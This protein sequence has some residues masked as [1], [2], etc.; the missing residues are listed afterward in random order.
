MNKKMDR[1]NILR[2][3]FINREDLRENTHVWYL[4]GDNINR[5]GMG[6][7][8]GAMRGEPNAIGIATKVAPFDD[9]A[10]FFND[11]PNSDYYFNTIL[12]DFKKVFRILIHEI[13]PL[14]VIPYDG[15]GTG[16]SDLPTHAPKLNKWLNN[17]AH[18]AVLIKNA[19]EVKRTMVLTAT[20]GISGREEDFETAYELF[21]EVQNDQFFGLYRLDEDE[22]GTG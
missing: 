17:F 9:K 14:I 8:A 3:K 19:N 16:L 11:G 4:F 21:M 12:Q 2:Q 20:S 18:P 5:Q 22:R 10:S 7:Q 6:G 1:S 15:L 13:N